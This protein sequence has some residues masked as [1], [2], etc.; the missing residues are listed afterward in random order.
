M[1]E[2]CT[3]ERSKAAVAI[4]SLGVDVD[5]AKALR[6]TSNEIRKGI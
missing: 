1:Q 4:F 6:A 2:G 5:K 3:L